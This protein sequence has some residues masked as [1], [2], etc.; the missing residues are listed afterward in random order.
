MFI[1]ALR[2]FASFSCDYLSIYLFNLW[3]RRNYS[4]FYD[5]NSSI[6]IFLYI[7][8][9]FIFNLWI[10]RITALKPIFKNV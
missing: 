4:H 3:L 7:L 1:L 8:I 9:L 6:F 10:K 2:M 5:S